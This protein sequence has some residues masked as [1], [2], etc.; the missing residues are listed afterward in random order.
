MGPIGLIGAIGERK[1]MHT[2]LQDIRYGVR[3]LLVKPAVAP[4]VRRELIRW[5][6]CA[7]NEEWHRL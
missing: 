3:T 4:G 6:P 5:S 7:T 1:D 2:L